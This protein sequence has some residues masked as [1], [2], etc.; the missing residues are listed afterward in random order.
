MRFELLS[1]HLLVSCEQSVVGTVASLID[2]STLKNQ[3]HPS[4]IDQIWWLRAESLEIQVRT[5]KG[6]RPGVPEMEM[7]ASWKV[8]FFQI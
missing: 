5:A 7:Q 3:V 4:K 8:L 1:D 2:E 6:A